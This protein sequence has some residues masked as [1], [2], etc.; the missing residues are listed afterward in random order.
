MSSSS[1]TSPVINWKKINGKW[2]ECNKLMG[3]TSEIPETDNLLPQLLSATAE[4][5]LISLR[6]SS[7][8]SSVSSVSSIYS[9]E[10]VDTDTQNFFSNNDGDINQRL[11]NIERNERKLYT[12]IG[13]L[14][15]Q[16][17]AALQSNRERNQR[18][19]ELES[20]VNRLDQYG[21]RENIEI[22]GIPSRVSDKILEKEVIKILH[23]IGLKWIEPY[24]IVGCHRI[25][26]RDRYGNRNVI[27][28]FLHRKDSHAALSHKKDLINCKEIGYDH[29]FMAENLCPAFRSILNELKDLKKKGII[30][31]VWV[32]NGTV[33]YKIEDKESVKPTKVFHINNIFNLKSSLSEVLP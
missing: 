4:V 27:V 22:S 15:K 11:A 20:Q 30:E 28:R 5:P 17:D 10:S 14:N 25:G 24:S 2:I 26:G 9:R 19:V 18:I 12:E 6:N 21:R 23:Q 13:K 31:A 32:S 29:L 1:S 8:G 16:L 7:S 3:G 33:K